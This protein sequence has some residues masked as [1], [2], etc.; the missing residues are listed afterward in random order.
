MLESAIQ[1]QIVNYLHYKNIYFFTVPNEAAGGGRGAMIRMRKLKKMGLRS[2]VADLVLLL[3]GGKT[4]FLEVKT[5][6]GRQSENQKEFEKEIK[7]LDFD[8]YIV[9]SVEDVEEILKN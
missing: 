5:D 4:V 3:K 9:R 2:G 7:K 8:Y 1:I 6:K